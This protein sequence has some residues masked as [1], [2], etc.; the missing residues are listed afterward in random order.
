MSAVLFHKASRYE[1]PKITDGTEITARAYSMHEDR[2]GPDFL[3]SET[4]PSTENVPD[5]G[6]KDEKCILF[7][8]SKGGWHDSFNSDPREMTLRINVESLCVH[9]VNVIQID[10]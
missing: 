9:E 4:V 10:T 8:F 1:K 7:E 6:D 3:I 5:E 2:L